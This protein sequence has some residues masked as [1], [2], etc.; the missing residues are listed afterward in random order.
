MR[1]LHITNHVQQIGNGIVN[2]AVDLACLQTQNGHD[3]AVAS[4]GGRRHRR[5]DAVPVLRG[6]LGSACL[7]RG[8][9]M[10]AH[11]KDQPATAGVRRPGSAGGAGGAGGNQLV[12]AHLAHCHA[13]IFPRE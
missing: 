3:V 8:R 10:A 6:H 13:G 7:P 1:V 2:V 5:M 11:A 4:A 12:P 9:A